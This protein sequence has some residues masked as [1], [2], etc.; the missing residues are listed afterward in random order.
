MGSSKESGI[1]PAALRK[2]S[3]TQA[4]AAGSAA[5]AVNPVSSH[6]WK[7]GM[8]IETRLHEK[9]FTSE[10]SDCIS[11]EIH[12]AP[13]HGSPALFYLNVEDAVAIINTLSSAVGKAIEAR[14]PIWPEEKS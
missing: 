9:S 6:V 3:G 7:N 14:M 11:L 10:P 1:K 4:V 12:P 5:A 13:G 2:R 8:R